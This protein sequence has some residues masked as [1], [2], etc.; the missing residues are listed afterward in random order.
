MDQL[1]VPMYHTRGLGTLKECILSAVPVL[2]IPLDLD[3]PSNAARIEHH[4][5]GHSCPPEQ[6][7]PRRIEHLTESLL[8]NREM[9][10]STKRMSTIFHRYEAQTPA[11]EFLIQQAKKA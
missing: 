5:L 4:G 2:V 8:E 11:V 1:C 6:C 9:V 3:Q 7:S 10:S